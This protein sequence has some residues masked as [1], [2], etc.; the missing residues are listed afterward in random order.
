MAIVGLILTAITGVALV[1]GVFYGIY[2]WFVAAS[3]MLTIGNYFKHDISPWSAR[4][5][6]NPFNALIVT[7]WLTPEG[8]DRARRFWVAIGKF[9]ACVLIPFALAYAT[10]MITGVQLIRR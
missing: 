4:T 3:L 6:F 1:V 8:Q 2:Q 10:E 7:S 9:L 5:L